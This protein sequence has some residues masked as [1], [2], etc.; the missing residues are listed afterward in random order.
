MI[1][2]AMGLLWMWEAVCESTA[3]RAGHMHLTAARA[4][5]ESREGH[6]SIQDEPP[7]GSAGGLVKGCN[8]WRRGRDRLR[9][10]GRS[11][12]ETQQAKSLANLKV[13]TLL[14]MAFLA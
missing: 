10:K 4:E 9:S 1:R 11:A 2:K 12:K 5:L 3:P 6:P 7:W 13:T 8:G 14:G